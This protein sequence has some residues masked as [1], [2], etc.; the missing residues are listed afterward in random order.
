MSIVLQLKVKK[1]KPVLRGIN[2]YWSII[3]ERHRQG[4]PFTRRGI[5][6]ASNSDLASIRDFIRRLERAGLI[7]RVGVEASGEIMFRPLIV[8]SAAPRVRRD[9]TV[10]ES[11]PATRCMWN[12]MR[13]PM[14]RQGF[15]YRD[16]VHWGSTD[17]T[18][19]SVQTAKSYIKSL[20]AAGYLIELQT[21]NG[22]RPSTWRLDP[23][24][25]TGPAAP[26]ILRTK[27]V[28]DP[29]R[30]EVYGPAVADE[31]QP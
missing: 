19:I 18:P 22:H 25:N 5:D 16:L 12:L 21:G 10:I 15:T 7:E 17:E 8:Q 6:A 30:A 3:M 13:A 27:M 20:N 23:K 28:Y 11:Q 4:Q 29:N 24:M 2:H 26:M 1:T 31:G 9:G 14:A